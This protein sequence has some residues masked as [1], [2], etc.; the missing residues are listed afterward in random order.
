MNVKLTE[1]PIMILYE[2]V[3]IGRGGDLVVASTLKIRMCGDKDIWMNV[4]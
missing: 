4:N 1:K 3:R 2:D